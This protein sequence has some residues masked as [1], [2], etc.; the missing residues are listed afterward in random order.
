MLSRH[1]YS[2]YLKVGYHIKNE[3]ST[4]F[5]KLVLTKTK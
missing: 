4:N 2:S 5:M 3:I 1:N